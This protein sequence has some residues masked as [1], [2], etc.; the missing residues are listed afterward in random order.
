M[1]GKDEEGDVSY[2]WTRR[3][4]DVPSN[5]PVAKKKSGHRHL[6]YYL[7]TSY[8]PCQPKVRSVLCWSVSH[9]AS[10]PCPFVVHAMQCLTAAFGTG[11]LET[12]W[13]QALKRIHFENLEGTHPVSQRG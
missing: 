6:L 11:P 4:R 3:C 10:S 5:L 12:I 8:Q 13:S 9:Q 1:L 2:R 7:P